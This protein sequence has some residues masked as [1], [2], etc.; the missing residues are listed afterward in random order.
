MHGQTPT[1]EIYNG[2]HPFQKNSF[3]APV[4]NISCIG[5]SKVLQ[6]D[7]ATEPKVC[8]IIS[9]LIQRP[10]EGGFQGFQEA[11]FSAWPMSKSKRSRYSKRAPMVYLFLKLRYT[12]SFLKKNS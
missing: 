12:Q 10:T 11:T 4:R 1:P 6:V 5:Y 7:I 8:V 9:G 2:T 3:Q